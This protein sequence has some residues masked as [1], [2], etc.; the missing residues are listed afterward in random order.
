M[1]TYQV[2]TDRN[3]EPHMLDIE[4]L[5]NISAVVSATTRESAA[6][7]FLEYYKSRLSVG[8][9]INVAVSK[10]EEIIYFKVKT[11]WWIFSREEIVDRKVSRYTF[12]SWKIILE[13]DGGKDAGKG[14]LKI[15]DLVKKEEDYW[16]EKFE[17]VP[18]PT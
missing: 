8:E 9:T 12:K 13:K 15:D 10:Y 11:G 14:L 2:R 4:M 6:K 16:T 18:D 1:N 3:S 7:I 5:P 17:I